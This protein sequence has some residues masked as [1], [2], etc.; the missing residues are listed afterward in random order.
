MT[1]FNSLT[2]AYSYADNA[3]KMMMVIM[4]EGRKYLVCTAA[5]AEKLIKAGHEVA[6]RP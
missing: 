2:L 1:Q 5:K 3:D 4:G 6:P